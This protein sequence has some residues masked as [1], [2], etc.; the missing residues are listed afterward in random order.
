MT[1]RHLRAHPPSSPATGRFHAH[2]T[3]VVADVDAFAAACTRI[4]AKPTVVDLERGPR[5]Q[6]DAMATRYFVDEAPG[7][8]GRIAAAL[9]AAGDALEAAGFP[10]L[11]VKLEHEGGA[12]DAVFDP[13]RYHEVHVKL[14]IP[15]ASFG[16]VRPRLEGLVPG[17]VPSRNPVAR[18]R[19]VVHQFV[20][21]RCRR[22]GRADADVVVASLLAAVASLGV[23]VVETKREDVVF[24]TAVALDAW[25][26]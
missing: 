19:G 10:V 4:A 26:A 22:G 16:A 20:N 14:A 9:L 17:A 7:A 6:R 5:A 12:P 13:L 23:D 15:E 3:A 8:V 2:L 18:K 24:D 21:L 1:L 25:W 11:R